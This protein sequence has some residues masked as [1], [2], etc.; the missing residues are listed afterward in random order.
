MNKF[1]VVGVVPFST[2]QLFLERLFPPLELYR[3]NIPLQG[4]SEF[5]VYFR[6]AEEPVAPVVVVAVVVVTKVGNRLS[7]PSVQIPPASRE[8]G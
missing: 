1:Y 4:T 7:S 3:L 2:E 8:D 5:L 6:F